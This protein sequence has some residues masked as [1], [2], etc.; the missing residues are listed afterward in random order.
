MKARQSVLLAVALLCSV[1]PVCAMDEAN[2]DE[3]VDTVA[4]AAEMP[5]AN[6][7]MDMVVA[8]ETATPQ[9]PQEK[10]VKKPVVADKA[11]AVMEEE[12]VTPTETSVEAEEVDGN[13]GDVR[14]V[15]EAMSR[16]E[17]D[18]ADEADHIG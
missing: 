8:E 17:A 18:Q 14:G 12:T 15:F 9:L 3:A 2:A 7:D 6:G 11:E 4:M 16:E 5:E 1:A 10:M 13:N